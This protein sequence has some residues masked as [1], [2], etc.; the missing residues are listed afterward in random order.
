MDEKAA[1]RIL[2]LQD[3]IQADMEYRHLM[4]EHDILN[5]RLLSQLETMNPEQRD[6]V[7]DYIG[8]LI[9]IGMK[10]LVFSVNEHAGTK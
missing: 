2:D 8:L 3:A 10:M 1:R 7:M 6:A 4:Q 5:S 9:E